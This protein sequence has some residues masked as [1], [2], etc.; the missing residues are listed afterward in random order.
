MFDDVMQ[1]SLDALDE[2]LGSY[3]KEEFV[4]EMAKYERNEGIRI[5]DINFDSIIVSAP[6]VIR[7]SH[8][9]DSNLSK[10]FDNS[11]F[12]LIGMAA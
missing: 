1:A 3:T 7:T 10:S 11:N 4:A 12:N 9:I 6:V 8:S 2:L 5:D